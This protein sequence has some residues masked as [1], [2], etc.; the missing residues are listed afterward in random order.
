MIRMHQPFARTLL[1]SAVG[2]QYTSKARF[3]LL[4]VGRPGGL[5]AT[6]RKPIDP[7]R[8]SPV[9]RG[10]RETVETIFEATARILQSEGKEALNTNL[11]AEK[12]GVSIGAL[13]GYFPNKEA[14]LLE[15]ARRELD[16][17][18]ARVAAALTTQDDGD[19]TDP[20]RKAIR[21]LIRGYGT[22]SRARRILM[23]TLFAHGGSEDMARPVYEI[24]TL[25]ARNSERVL[26]RGAS[27]PSPIGMFVLT[28]AVDSVIR[29]A[30][31]EGVSFISSMAFEDELVRLVSGYFALPPGAGAPAEGR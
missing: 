9:R 3:S 4:E 7:K 14:I 12:A 29:A 24:A 5:M 28:S 19:P 11:I 30:T 31:Y 21:A 17:I 6:R 1:D 20:V 23:E 15:M 13:Y 22:R 26:P 16:L 18:Q 2:W 25:I 27:L 8:R 10:A